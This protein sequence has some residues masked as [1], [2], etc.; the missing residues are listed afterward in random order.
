MLVIYYSMAIYAR[1]FLRVKVN[2]VVKKDDFE[3]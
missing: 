1:E 3:A 2:N